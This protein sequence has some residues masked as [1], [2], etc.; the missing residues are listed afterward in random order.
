M[1]VNLI[2]LMI[3]SSLILFGCKI[4]SKTNRIN[5]FDSFIK[6]IPFIDLPY[7]TTCGSCCQSVKLDLDSSFIQKY[8]LDGSEVVGKLSETD[9]YVAIL[10]AGG[11]DYYVPIIFV[12]DK[13]GRLISKQQ[14]M[15]NY[16]GSILGFYGN[17][18]LD[19]DKQLQI[20]EIDTAL[21]FKTDTVEFKII[22]TLK[23]DIKVTRFKINEQGKIIK[24]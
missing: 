17:Y 12:F 5:D 23:R 22:D 10:V 14:F 24:K 4:N 20:T 18:Y 2:N 16:C 11:A 8:E 9:K 13:K 19:I 15:G 3:L 6:T 7:S 21:V 1:K